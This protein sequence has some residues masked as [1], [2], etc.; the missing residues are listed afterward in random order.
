MVESKE[1]WVRRADNA[2]D[3][4]YALSERM[5]S[6]DSALQKVTLKPEEIEKKRADLHRKITD[7]DKART[8]AANELSTGERK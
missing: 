4:L 6:T 8:E 3:H 1:S 5:N 2:E 7:A